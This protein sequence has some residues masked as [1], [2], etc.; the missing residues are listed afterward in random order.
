MHARNHVAKP[1]A[2]TFQMFFFSPLCLHG[3]HE[4]GRTAGELTLRDVQEW[5]SEREDVATFLSNFTEA[6]LIISS[7]EVDP[8]MLLPSRDS[9]PP[10]SVVA[11]ER[12]PQ[13]T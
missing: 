8:D 3:L 9:S 5:I 11:I 4:H 2:G 1:R 10:T 13:H 12:F 7:T 6:R